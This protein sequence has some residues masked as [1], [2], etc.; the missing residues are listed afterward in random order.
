MHEQSAVRN[1]D[2]EEIV[3][4]V[5]IPDAPSQ[6]A[7]PR[8][9]D[10]SHTIDLRLSLPWLAGRRFYLAFV[11]GRERRSP[12]R[13]SQERRRHPV[14]RLA[15]VVLLLAMG[16]VIGLALFAALQLAAVLILNQ[17]STLVVA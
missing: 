2:L 15:N 8:S 1:R 16:T 11:A 9:W 7:A 10:G 4:E 12:A 14:A 3:P 5:V 13:R 17:S 6:A